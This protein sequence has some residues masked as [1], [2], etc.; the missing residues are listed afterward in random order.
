MYIS[1]KWP[2]LLFIPYST[3][4]LKAKTS[5][6]S[7]I[8]LKPI[9]FFHKF[10]SALA[11]VHVVLLQTQKFFCEYSHGDLTV[12]VLSF[13]RFVLYGIRMGIKYS[14]LKIKE[15]GL[16]TWDYNYHVHVVIT[17]CN[18]Q[19]VYTNHNVT[20]NSII[21]CNICFGFAVKLL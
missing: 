6:F 15:C 4:R 5:Q 13:G 8:L 1:L 12:N 10:Q 3:K 18:P 16:A 14:R 20:L 7:W 9:M 2:D 21:V 11:L 19:H 17:W